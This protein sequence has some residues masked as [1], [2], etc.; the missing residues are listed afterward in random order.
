M[1][2]PLLS[3]QNT[4]RTTW[5][6]M[7]KFFAM[8]GLIFEWLAP[9][10]LNDLGI[11]AGNTN[12]AYLLSQ[13]SPTEDSEAAS[14]IIS[15]TQ[16]LIVVIPSAFLY[17]LPVL[18]EYNMPNDKAAVTAGILFAILLSLP[19]L[20]LGFFTK[21][22]F[23]ALGVTDS[24]CQLLKDYFNVFCL[25]LPFLMIATSLSKV[26]APL[27]CKY[28]LYPEALINFIC[29][30]G[31]SNF[32][33]RY[34]HLPNIKP[35]QILA[36]SNLV[37]SIARILYYM[38]AYTYLDKFEKW[39]NMDL[40][41]YW[42]A[43]TC[44]LNTGWRL[45]L[46]LGSEL[47]ALYFLTIL[48]IKFLASHTMNL[49]ILNVMSQCFM[50]SVILTLSMAITAMNLISKHFK[51]ENA[52]DQIRPCIS[53]ML[54]WSMIYNTLLFVVTMVQTNAIVRLFMPPENNMNTGLS[55]NFQLMFVISYFGLVFSAFKDIINMSQRAL[56]IFSLPMKVSISG[57]WGIGIP[58]AILLATCTDLGVGGLWLG[59]NIGNIVTG[60]FLLC[61]WHL[62]S[63]P[64][65]IQEILSEGPGASKKFEQISYC[66][67]HCKAI[68]FSSNNEQNKKSDYLINS[69]VQNTA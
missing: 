8:S 17:V 15:T 60:L 63:Q 35:I 50:F 11:D 16:V 59:Y 58:L 53:T 37:C 23:S 55:G 4:E 10:M 56:N 25:A 48:T 32:F 24:V 64:E 3:I 12:N 2:Q 29:I 65:V 30:T 19:G 66:L 43:A 38:I 5:T 46:Q 14:S 44:L 45:C 67:K 20:I 27:G 33:I 28:L 47:L 49:A 40:K 57:V 26:A 39:Q 68:L 9:Q 6:M 31:F 34:Y 54:V 51:G 52:Y 62:V 21:E 42:K 61:H 36:F 18:L 22:I 7:A 41:K 69:H 13:Q 1:Q